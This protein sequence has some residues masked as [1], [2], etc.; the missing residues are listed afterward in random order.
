MAAFIGNKLVEDYEW[1]SSR[2]MIDSAHLV[3]GGVDLDPA[4]STK[5]NE[6]VNAKKYYTPLE[7]GLN[8]QEW[9][10]NVYL[11]PPKHSYFWH[12]KSQ[13][14]KMTRGLS[15]TLTSSYS[16]WWRTLKRKWLSG[17]VEQ[18]IYFANAPDMFMYCQDIF[19]HPICIF[20]TRPMLTQHFYHTGEIKT[21]TTCTSFAIFL[22][23][24]R[25]V[26]DARQ[27]FVE[28]Y[29]EMG[30]ILI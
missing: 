29:G 1:I 12:S 25:N 6:Y 13:R 27:H 2:D 15:P 14:W 19:D 23:P 18:G 21:R 3:M 28:V 24:R 7:D 9:F 4:S 16:I 20:R 10:G 26:E 22:Q 30:R 17:E 8:E 5:A 11:F